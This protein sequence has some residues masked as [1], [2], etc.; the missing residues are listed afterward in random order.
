MSSFGSAGESSCVTQSRSNENYDAVA[1][2]MEIPVYI[3][4]PLLNWTRS[5]LDRSALSSV[6][7]K[8]LKCICLG[9]PPSNFAVDCNKM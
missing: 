8:D 4:S 7:C 1:P 9:S 5:L 3:K 2:L 6:I